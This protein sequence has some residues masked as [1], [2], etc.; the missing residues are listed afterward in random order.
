MATPVPSRMWRVPLILLV[1]VSLLLASSPAE[2]AKAPARTA[3]SAHLM[4]ATALMGSTAGGSGTVSPRGGSVVVQRQVG[5][6]GGRL[7]HKKPAASGTFTF[8]VRAKTAVTWRLRV[9]RAA[10]KTATAGVSPALTLHV[11]R[12]GFAVAAAA[13]QATAPNPVIITGSVAPKASGTVQ[14]QRLTGSHWV[15]IATARLTSSTFTASTVQPAGS[16]RLRVVKPYTTTVA[17]GTSAAL[18]VT[19]Q[20]AIP[21]PTVTTVALPAARVGRAFFA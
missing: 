13:A 4:P 2:A 18:T 8:S 16:L 3:I 15:T 21:A 7:A 10:S 19:I 6:S 12:T 1:A 11:V 14:V 5:K 9:T 20:P 17:A